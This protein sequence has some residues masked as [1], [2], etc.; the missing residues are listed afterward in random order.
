MHG[1]NAAQV[2]LLASLLVVAGAPSGAEAQKVVKKQRQ[3]ERA[4][5]TKPC[6][7]GPCCER[8]EAL[9]LVCESAQDGK[10]TCG[11]H[12]GDEEAGTTLVPT[13]DVMAKWGFL[14]R[15]EDDAV[16]MSNRVQPSRT[17]PCGAL[18]TWTI[19]CEP[20]AEPSGCPLAGQVPAGT[21]SATG[22]MSASVAA[23]GGTLSLMATTG[24]GAGRAQV[25]GYFDP[26][27][28]A[29]DFHTETPQCG[30][31]SSRYEVRSGW[32]KGSRTGGTACCNTSR[33]CR[34]TVKR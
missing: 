30:K 18:G 13:A 26:H 9:L 27:S 23:S 5:P 29:A 19:D 32:I 16:A 12:G 10:C 28:C 31:G 11:D 33:N 3:S 2:I 14:C 25:R 8:C 15:E 7:P 24:P 1:M 34:G 22:V 17:D 21:L 4:A 20:E 6:P